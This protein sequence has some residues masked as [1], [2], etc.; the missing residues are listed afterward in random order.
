ME[1]YTVC[2]DGNCR[3]CGEVGLAVHV[4]C[5]LVAGA[6]DCTG[7]AHHKHKDEYHCTVPYCS[8]SCTVL[9]CN[10]VYCTL[11][12]QTPMCLAVLQLHLVL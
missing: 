11:L 7:Q 1:R 4:D 5:D 9:Y 2:H 3:R 12:R 8:S 10:V 6:R